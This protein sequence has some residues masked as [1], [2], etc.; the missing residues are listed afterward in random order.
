MSEID[1]VA[2]LI[3]EIEAEQSAHDPVDQE[4]VSNEESESG[5]S[6]EGTEED[7]NT[8]KQKDEVVGEA[9]AEAPQGT[10]TEATETTESEPSKTET[11][12]TDAEVDNWKVTLPPPPSAYTGPQPEI[13]PTTGQ[14]TNMDPM[15][16]A[17]YMRE[18]TK[19]ELRAELY[20]QMV[21]TQ[22]LA[23]AEQILPELKT[24]PSIRKMVEN[25]RVASI[26]NGQQIDNVEAAKQVRD[27]LGLAPAKLQAAKAEGAQSAKSSIE[28][29]KNASLET[30]SSQKDSGTADEVTALQ[31]RV[32]RGDDEA[33]AE[34]LGIWDKAG[35]L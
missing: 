19:S 11:Q 14:V 30:S 21:E 8:E 17:T 18:S 24:N 26:I 31:K 7:T 29:Q 4:A 12:V 33:F 6:T 16:Y 20:T 3:G 15:E 25:A 9:T 1:D 32:Q 28:I 23:V 5:S 34:L 22:S 13:D 10:Q 2:N 27:A 35:K